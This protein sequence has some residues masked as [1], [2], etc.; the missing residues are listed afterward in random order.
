MFA[1]DD[2]KDFARNLLTDLVEEE[3]RN[4]EYISLPTKKNMVKGLK[5]ALESMN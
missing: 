4:R 5:L 1:S 2:R 3:T